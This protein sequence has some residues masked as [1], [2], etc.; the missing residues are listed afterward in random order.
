MNFLIAL[1]S[2]KGCLSSAEANCAAAQGIRDACPQATVTTIPVSDGGEGW[3]DAIH[4][5]IGGKFYTV[6]TFDPLMRPLHAPYL[7]D[8]KTNT[9]FIESAKVIGLGLLEEQHRHPIGLYSSGMADIL[10]EAWKAHPG[11]RFVVG[12]GGSATCDIG[13]GFFMGLED[14]EKELNQ[15]NKEKPK[16]IIASDVSN[17]LCG[18]IG[19]AR[20]FAP[21]KGATPEEVE[22][23]ERRASFTALRW[24]R[25]LNGKDCSNTPGAGAAGGL[26]YAFMQWLDAEYRPGIDILLEL[27]DFKRKAADADIIITGEGSADRQ[28]LLGKVPMG[29]LKC[30][31]NKN[32]ELPPKSK[33]NTNKENTGYFPENVNN[34]KYVAQKPYVCLIAGKV[35]DKDLLLHAGFTSV[36][37]INPPNLPLSLAMQKQTAINNI[38]TTVSKIINSFLQQKKF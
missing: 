4:H 21:Q 23:L 12:L 18:P 26:G 38:R 29:I 14:Y 31:Q 36:D 17:P 16:V 30:V 3:L 15:R 2:F 7:F 37:S 10:V 34:Q 35:H 11:C 25:L 32:N 1:D 8:S 20:M 13:T 19:A 22:I 6:K 27:T 28:T 5:A 9:V 24:K 33:E